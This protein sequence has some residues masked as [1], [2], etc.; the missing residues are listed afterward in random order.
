[1]RARRAGWAG[2]IAGAALCTLIGAP[3]LAQELDTPAPVLADEIPEYQPTGIGTGALKLY[4]SATVRLA[5]DSNIYAKSTDP[6][7]DAIVTFSP[8]VVADYDHGTLHVV[9]TAAA[10]IRRF[11]THTTENSNGALLN[12]HASLDLGNT[13]QLI[14]D[15][16]WKRAV[17]DRGDPEART[18]DTVGPRLSNVWSGALDYRHQGGR[19]GF[20]AHGGVDRFDFLA[21]VDAERD[22]TQVVAS[23]R[24]S[25]RMH[26]LT[27]VFGE[28]FANHRDFRLATDFSGID[29]DASTIGARCGVSIDPGGLWSGDIGVGVF[30]FDPQ[31]PTLKGRTGLSVQGSLI[32]APTPRLAFTLEAFRG[33]VATVRSGTST[34]VD[35]RVQLGFQ[36]EIRHNLHWSGAVVYRRSKFV[37]GGTQRTLGGESEV[38]YRFNR[39]FAIAAVARYADRNSNRASERFERFRG[40]IELRLRY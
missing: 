20:Q 38:E 13:D 10:D 5:Y 34:R 1:M 32:Y 17:E 31:D 24:L 23:G 3:G 14:A 6:A 37:G 36:Q 26:G 15:L 25:Y 35:T 18:D 9:G 2:L 12:G 19:I 16:G 8:R 33:D 7:D 4:P 40:A 22:F 29:R 27:S 21:P 11:A 39:R 30:H 28:V